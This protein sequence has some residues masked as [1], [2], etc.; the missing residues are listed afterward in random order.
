MTIRRLRS[1]CL[2]RVAVVLTVAFTGFLTAF[3]FRAEREPSRFDR[4]AI[5]DPTQTLDVA[6]QQIDDLSPGDST[7]AVWDAFR[8]EHGPRW[9]IHIARRSGAPLLV[10]GQ[11]IPWVAGSGNALS[12]GAPP[13]LDLLERSLRAFMGRHRALLLA[14]DG[15]LVLN[16]QASGLLTPET[17][18]VVFDRRIGGVPVA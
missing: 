2:R 6:T 15:E 18:Q 12:P 9:S 4:L 17:W 16:R 3:A 8:A 11:G 13:T 14:D 5:G 7:R 10:E 1:N